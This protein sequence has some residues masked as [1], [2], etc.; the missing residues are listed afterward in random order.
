MQ[1]NI[2]GPVGTG[3]QGIVYGSLLIHTLNI[4]EVSQLII[5]VNRTVEHMR[6]SSYTPLR[7]SICSRDKSCV[8]VCADN[9]SSSEQI[10]ARVAV[11]LSRVLC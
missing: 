6:F 10:Q 4:N 3:V 11:F 2:Y 8:C 9:I 5:T 7:H 1:G